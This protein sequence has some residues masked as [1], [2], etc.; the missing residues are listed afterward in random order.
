VC[1]YVFGQQLL[2]ELTTDY[3]W[4]AISPNFCNSFHA[5]AVSSLNMAGAPVMDRKV[6]TYVQFTPLITMPTRPS[7]VT[8]LKTFLDFWSYR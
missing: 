1:I 6:E 2:I 4:R 8:E 5:V 3:M 7:A